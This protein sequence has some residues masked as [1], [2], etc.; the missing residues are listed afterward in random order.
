MEM[1]NRPFTFEEL[2][3]LHEVESSESRLNAIEKVTEDGRKI[4][5]CST[6]PYRYELMFKPSATN[7]LVS[8]EI[9][10]WD[11]I[12]YEMKSTRQE[13][14]HHVTEDEWK[15]LLSKGIGIK[16]CAI[17][18]SSGK[19]K[20]VECIG[21][22]P[23]VDPATNLPCIPGLHELNQD[24]LTIRHIVLCLRNPNYTFRSKGHNKKQMNYIEEILN[25]E[26]DF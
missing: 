4:K 24:Y 5:I 3:Q 16:K 10:P 14:I 13:K 18:H 25:P 22:H 21:I 12:H 26:T 17:F 19:L 2:A 7:V 20:K 15:F 1:A 8:E 6:P 11:N 9:V 23:N